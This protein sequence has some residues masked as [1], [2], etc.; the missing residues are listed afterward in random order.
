MENKEKK[1]MEVGD[2]IRVVDGLF[3]GCCGRIVDINMSMR[4]PYR[5]EITK[6]GKKQEM[7]YDAKYIEPDTRNDF[8][9]G[10]TVKILN[11]LYAG[12]IGNVVEID[13]S[14]CN[15]SAPFYIEIDGVIGKMHSWYSAD[16]LK[17]VKTDKKKENDDIKVG[18]N[19][20]VTTKSL[21]RYGEIGVVKMIRSTSTGAKIYGVHFGNDKNGCAFSEYEI[22]KVKAKKKPRIV[23]YQDGNKVIAKNLENG[24]IGKTTCCKEDIFDFN[25]GAFI[26]I[27]RLFGYDEIFES[28]KEKIQDILLS[29]SKVLKS[30]S[31]IQGI[32]VK[33]VVIHPDQM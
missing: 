30:I 23:V 6:K 8:K 9:I 4:F 18:D 1:H 16:C 5:V 14:E 28:Q 19:V 20:K 7:F 31:E 12:Y 10:D 27:S 29:S 21:G 24:K 11:G 2:K 15:P 26:A 17:F 22:E 13:M 32:D 33:Q 25:K 3:K